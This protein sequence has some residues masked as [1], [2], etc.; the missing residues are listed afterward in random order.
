MG[1]IT[2]MVGGIAT[3]IPGAE[4]VG[5]AIG[6]AGKVM[7]AA[8]GGDVEA[9]ITAGTEGASKIVAN[10]VDDPAVAQQIANAGVGIA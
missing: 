2:D 9:A 8:D 10:N 3:Q 6:T 4:D 1:G 7:T 5:G